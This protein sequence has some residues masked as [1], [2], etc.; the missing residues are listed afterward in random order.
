MRGM[1]AAVAAAVMCLTLDVLPVAGQEAS[2]GPP[3]SIPPVVGGSISVTV[4]QSG[5]MGSQIVAIL[6]SELTPDPTT[7]QV[8]YGSFTVDVTR[9]P[10]RAT[11]PILDGAPG[12]DPRP[13]SERSIAL[14]PPGTYTL[15]VWIGRELGLWDPWTPGVPIDSI[16]LLP[17]VVTAGTVSEVGLTVP[18]GDGS[19][20]V[21]IDRD[22]TC[23][24]LEP[25]PSPSAG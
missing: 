15:V 16:C 1:A 9:D 18:P 17:V 3:A 8:A 24:P 22:L 21:P 7:T 2:G 25:S 10:F 20:S 14:V 13:V 6:W 11:R 23:L 4:G 19:G 5:A 12:L